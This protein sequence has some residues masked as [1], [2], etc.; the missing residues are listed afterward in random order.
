MDP[1]YRQFMTMPPAKHPPARVLLVTAVPLDGDD[2]ARVLRENDLERA[3]VRVLAPSIND[4]ALAY[5]VSDADEAIAE[6]AVA[7]SATAGAV[8]RVTGANVSAAVGDSDPLTAIGDALTGFPA[9]RIVT[10]HREG[11]AAGYHEERLQPDVI[12]RAFGLPVRSY[13]VKD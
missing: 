10:V 9:D 7:A 13:V 12:Q 3:S 6:A 1:G 8:D 11:E 2:I 4:S 5:W